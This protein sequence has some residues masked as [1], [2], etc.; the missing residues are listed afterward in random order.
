MTRK[1]MPESSLRKAL[2]LR[3]VKELADDGSF[4]RG[5]EYQADGQVESITEH[6]DMIVAEVSGTRDYRIKLWA[7]GGRLDYSCNCP[8]GAEGDFCKHC[9]A[10]CLEWLAHPREE[11]PARRRSGTRPVTINAVR[12]FL[13]QKEKSELVEMILTQL[14]ENDQLRDHLFMQAEKNRKKK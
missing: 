5:E 12:D 6:G 9:V 1:L 8:V 14:L 13:D 4:S 10:A 7:K 3:A 11:P 2:S